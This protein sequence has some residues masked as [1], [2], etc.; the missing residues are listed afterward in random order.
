[1]TNSAVVHLKYGEDPPSGDQFLLV[2]RRGRVRGDDFYISP[3]SRLKTAEVMNSAFASL[4]AA[5]AAAQTEAQVQ[6]VGIIY[7]RG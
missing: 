2:T 3:S 5:L 6:G 4:N 1:M 7:V